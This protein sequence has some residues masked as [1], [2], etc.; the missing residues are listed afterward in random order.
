[1]LGCT[2]A[3]DKDCLKKMTDDCDMHNLKIIDPKCIDLSK[4]TIRQDTSFQ[5]G[6]ST[7]IK[8]ILGKGEIQWTANNSIRKLIG[9]YYLSF[10]N[11]SD[12]TWRDLEYWAFLREVILIRIDK[13]NISKKFI[14]NETQYKNDTSLNYG[15]YNKNFDDFFGEAKWEIDISKQSYLSINKID[16]LNSNDIIVSGEYD[17]N[18]RLTKQSVDPKFQYE[19][20]IRFRCGQFKVKLF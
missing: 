4:Y 1:M 13:L 17:L 2:I 7:C 14:T 18:F 6:Y 9:G 5:Y 11:Y 20:I 16:T 10:S 15:L 19:E 12:S 8:S 3:C